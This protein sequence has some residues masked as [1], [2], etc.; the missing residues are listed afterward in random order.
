M[1]FYKYL[2]NEIKL[3]WNESF[4]KRYL[5]LSSTSFSTIISLEINMDTYTLTVPS[6]FLLAWTY[7]WPIHHW[8]SLEM[9][10]W[11]KWSVQMLPPWHQ[12]LHFVGLVS[13]LMRLSHG[14]CPTG[15]D[16]EVFNTCWVKL[17]CKKT[18]K[19]SVKSSDSFHWP[20]TY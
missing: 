16:E 18:S 19:F 5:S 14:I 20:Y 12:R 7:R 11:D 13:P 17:F 2:R 6:G 1:S 3:I 10:E 9:H 15:P 8:L 4:K